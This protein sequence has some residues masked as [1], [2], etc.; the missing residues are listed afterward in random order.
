MVRLS[1]SSRNFIVLGLIIILCL[2]VI[3]VSFREAGLIKKIK[4][5]TVDFFKPVQEKFSS[6]V[7]PFIKF[8]NSMKDYINLGEKYQKLLEENSVLRREY[9]DNINLRIEN[10]SLRKLLDIKLRKNYETVAARVIGFYESGWQSEI[11]L[12]A[13]SSEGVREGMCVINEDGLIGIV[14]QAGSSSSNVRLINDP[15]SA[16]GARILSSRQTGIIKGN[17]DKKI[18]LNYIPVEEPVFKGDIVVTSEYSNLPADIL[19]GRISRVTENPEGLYKVIEVEPFADFR[20]IEYV[21]V[22]KE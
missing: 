21:M 3:T 6:F 12:N 4:A 7:R 10:D 13:G 15:Q 17:Q 19:I 9:A 16:I 2:I 14:M 8:I 5:K 18:I 1:R 20:R 22:V 11:I